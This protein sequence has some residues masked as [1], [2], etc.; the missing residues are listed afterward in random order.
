MTQLFR[1]TFCVCSIARAPNPLI[2]TNYSH[3]IK[4]TQFQIFR[5]SFHNFQRLVIYDHFKTDAHTHRTA[6]L[7]RK[8]S[9]S[10]HNYFFKVRRVHGN[11][12]K[13]FLWKWRRKI[14]NFEPTM[15]IF[16]DVCFWH[17]AA[18]SFWW[19][20]INHRMVAFCVVHSLLLA[21][22]TIVVGKFNSS[23]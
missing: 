23:L 7:S 10:A 11:F 6:K 14:V 12:S 3:S 9:F 16:N 19:H 18:L 4:F 15:R 13:S 20:V 5:R 2:V 22:S 1:I 17:R 8:I 21:S